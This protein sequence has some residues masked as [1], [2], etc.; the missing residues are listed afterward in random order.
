MQKDE[1]LAVMDRY[2][3]ASAKRDWDTVREVLASDYVQHEP[4]VVELRGREEFIE[5]AKRWLEA[6]PPIDEGITEDLIVGEDRIAVRF[7]SHN[8]HQGEWLGFP[9][10]GKV[11]TYSALAIVRFASGQ[12]A[13]S[14]IYNDIPGMLKQM[15][16]KP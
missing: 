7:I 8:R 16:A 12:M 15:G 2:D 5:H 9:A 11:I 10:T 6:F 3:H 4:G 1:M 14:W 13:A